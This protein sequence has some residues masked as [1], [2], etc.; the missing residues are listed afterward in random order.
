MKRK[1]EKIADLLILGSLL[2]GF[3]VAVVKIIEQSTCYVN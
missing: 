1:L 2:F 3:I